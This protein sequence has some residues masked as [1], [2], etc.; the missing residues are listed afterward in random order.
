MTTTFTPLRS[1]L[2]RC[3]GVILNHHSRWWLVEFPR[4]CGDL[5]KVRCLTGQLTSAMAQRLDA[6]RANADASCEVGDPYPSNLYWS[7]L[8]F[9]A[10]SDKSPEAFDV[11]A[12]LRCSEADIP[13][14][15]RARVTIESTLF[16]LPSGFVSVLAA[17]PKED[18]PVL[19]IRLSG[20]IGST[21]EL[22][23]A[24]Y[25]PTYRPKSPWRDISHDAVGDSGSDILGWQYADDWIK[26]A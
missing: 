24:L 19:A 6:D 4:P 5:G 10:P 3:S 23:T 26:P 12:C 15:R 20:Y 8:F 16:P 17:L 21:F 11:E 25:M 2:L 1:P 22:L 13:D 9:L 14:V 7:G 18:R